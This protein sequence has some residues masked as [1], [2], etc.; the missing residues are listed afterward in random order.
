MLGNVARATHGET[1]EEVLGSGDARRG[2]QTFALAQGPLTHVQSGT[3]DGSASTLH[4]SVDG[5][6][7]QQVALA[8]RRRRRATATFTHAPGHEPHPST[9]LPADLVRFGDGVRGARLPSGSHNVRARYRKGIGAG[10]NLLPGQ[11][12]Q[13]MDR[14]LGLRGASNPLPSEG[15]TDPEPVDAARSSIPISTRTLGR[16]VSLQDYADFARAF[17]GVSRADARVLALRAGRTVVVSVTGPDGATAA[18]STIT[19]LTSALRSLGD[20]LVRVEV[21]AA[22]VSRFQVS[23]RVETAPD[24][25]PEAVREAVVAAL[26]QRFGAPARELGEPVHASA[27]IATAASVPG[28]A[29]VDLDAL[30]RVGRPTTLEARLVAQPA[31]L[32]STGQL[33][34]AELL[35]LSD[36]PPEV[37]A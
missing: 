6:T 16:A 7:W 35:A 21:A 30:H 18:G 11:L 31:H 33:L 28:V 34:G 27:V 22:D 1:V 25:D 4:V 26:R 9:G 2:F 37:T 19:H 24:R 15:G 20:P 3:A 17:A 23:M 12:A 10:G 14:P 36:N 13:P 29:S 32:S 8:L 5:T